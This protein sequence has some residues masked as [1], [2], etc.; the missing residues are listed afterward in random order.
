[1]VIQILT[2][3]GALFLI[4]AVG[5]LARARRIITDDVLD[6]LCR[7][8]LYVTL[9]FL[10]IYVLSTKCDRETLAALWMAPLFAASI[11]FIGYVVAEAAASFLRV[12]P[13]KRGT[14][15][16]LISFQNSGFLAIP[17]AV[18]LFGTEGVLTII[19]FNI[20]FNVLFWTFGVWLFNKSNPSFAKNSIKN[21]ANPGIIALALGV[22]FG[23]LGV[24]LP[25]FFLDGSRLLG[26][27]TIPLAMLV[28]GAILA[29]SK[30]R[31][32]VNFK[33]ISTIIFCRLI[34]MPLLFLGIIAFFKDLTPL[35][36][37]III[38]QACMPS[39]STTP[40]LARRFGGDHDLA[41]NG[42]FFTT[43]ISI[44][45]IPVFMSLI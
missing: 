30:F 32:G 5:G 31:S 45:T 14:F 6:N 33:V 44:I 22:L 39:A 29:S 34:F 43:L 7:I 26:D 37:S 25:R 21:L 4:L 28:V 23:T 36:R 8:V 20:G 40:L 42:V 1:M 18:V 12:P 41:A 35:M 24:K 16:F 3:I 11:I 15:T 27:A 13:E 9:P 17:I 38:L 2:K 10:F 19:I